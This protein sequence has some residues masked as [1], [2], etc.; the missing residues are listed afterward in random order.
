VA[1]FVASRGCRLQIGDSCGNIAAD[2][3][4]RALKNSGMAAIAAEFG[5]ELI[6]FDRAPCVAA[7]EVLARSV[8]R[9]VMIA[10][11]ALEADVF[12]N[13]PKLKTHRLTNLTGAI[14]NLYGT[15][16]SNGKKIVHQRQPKPAALAAVLVDML[17]AIKPRLNLMDGVIA[18]EGMGPNGGDAREVGV[19]IASG[20][21]VA[22]DAVA[23]AIIGLH[24][25]QID[26]VRMGAARGLGVGRL[27]DIEILGAPIAQV[28][29]A[30]FKLPFARGRDAAFAIVPRSP[31]AVICDCRN[32][33]APASSPR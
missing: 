12:F 18:M 3:T 11:A 27:Q 9:G 32:V 7:D 2:A 21:A 24:A 28:R 14:K 30:D 6:N 33:R 16:L 20:D 4:E 8:G 26:M 19:L 13:L 22:L 15:I 29:V 10:R 31:P 17:A 5:A 25:N 23:G 1:E